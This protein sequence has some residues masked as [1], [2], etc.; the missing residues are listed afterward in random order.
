MH[1]NLPELV[2]LQNT[3]LSMVTTYLGCKTFNLFFTI[4]F[5]TVLGLHGKVLIVDGYMGD[6]Y[7]KIPKFPLSDEAPL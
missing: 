4:M 6:F 7:E 2:K 3:S 1:D 5:C